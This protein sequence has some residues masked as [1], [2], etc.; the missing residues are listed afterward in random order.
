MRIDFTGDDAKHIYL[1]NL[2]DQLGISGMTTQVNIADAKARL[3]ELVGAA[4]RGEDIVL[5]RA[6]KPQV[7]L[8]AVSTITEA[9]EQRRAAKRQSAFGMYAHLIEGRAIDVRGLKH[10]AA[11]QEAEYERKFGPAR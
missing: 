8:V 1:T 4:V 2:P 7:R 3:S 5:A 10:T 11:E 6:G 9:D